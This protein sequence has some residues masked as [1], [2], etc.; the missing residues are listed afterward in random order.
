ML[1]I[2]TPAILALYLLSD[3]VA[4]GTQELYKDG[5]GPMVDN[6]T[7]VVRCS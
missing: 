6:H 5:N 2:H 3:I 1:R 7:G 4:G